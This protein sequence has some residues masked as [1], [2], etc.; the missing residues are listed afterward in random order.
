MTEWYKGGYYAI[1]F[2]R[3][4]LLLFVLIINDINLI[5]YYTITFETTMRVVKQ[6]VII[7]EK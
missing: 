5:D 3:T 7:N 4:N 6:C 1:K 2:S